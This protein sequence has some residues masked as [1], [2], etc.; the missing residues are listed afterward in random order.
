MLCLAPSHIVGQAP[1][2]CNNYFVVQ[3]DAKEQDHKSNKL[4]DAEIRKGLDVLAIDRHSQEENPHCDV[5]C[6]V[7]HC[8]LRSR[9]ILGY[10]H[11]INIDH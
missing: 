2:T 6:L 4:K 3:E 9:A 1:E 10:V 8:P 5:S 11:T 7:S